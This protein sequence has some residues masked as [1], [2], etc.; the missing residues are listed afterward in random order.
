[1]ASI[2]NNERAMKFIEKLFLGATVVLVGIYI[3]FML[4]VIWFL[5]QLLPITLFLFAF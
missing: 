3:W 5:L 1:L 2:C 4:Q